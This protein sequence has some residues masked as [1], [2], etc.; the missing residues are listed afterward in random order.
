MI[1]AQ[2][3]NE[4]LKE[5]FLRILEH[6]N[7]ELTDETTAN[8]VDGWESVTHMMLINEIEQELNIKFKLMDL[9][10][11]K[12]IGDLKAIIQKELALNA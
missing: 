11:M 5:V 12:N 7:F 2:E 8:D 3:I 10:Q 9:M 6:D 4:K 1:Q